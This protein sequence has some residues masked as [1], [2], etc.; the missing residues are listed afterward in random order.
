M[1]GDAESIIAYL[2]MKQ[3]ADPNFFFKINIDKEN[4]LSKL[5]WTDSQSH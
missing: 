4:R 1:N 3:D 2:L 5:F